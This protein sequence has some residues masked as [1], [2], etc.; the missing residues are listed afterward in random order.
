MVNYF[1]IEPHELQLLRDALINDDLYYIEKKFN[2]G[3]WLMKKKN[4]L[5]YKLLFSAAAYGAYKIVKFLLEKG[6]DPMVVN[7]RNDTLLVTAISNG[8]L[9]LAKFLII[10]G[11][12]VNFVDDN[13]KTIYDWICVAEKYC[14]VKYQ[15]INEFIE[16]VRGVEGLD[17]KTKATLT[18]KQL[19]IILGVG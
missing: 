13:K 11:L 3:K 4:N 6:F 12:D 7:L 10:Q 8:H 18:A 2:K 9:D 15:E 1:G 17:K 14:R 16:F 19:K 5:E